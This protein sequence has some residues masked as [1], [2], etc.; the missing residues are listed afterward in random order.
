MKDRNRID[1]FV[2]RRII[3]ALLIVIP[4]VIA[5]VGC[6]QK[7]PADAP[8]KPPSDSPPQNRPDLLQNQNSKTSIA[9][10][11]VFFLDENTGWVVGRNGVILH[12]TNGGVDWLP[13]PS[14]TNENLIDIKFI[15]KTTGWAA[16]VNRVL[17]TTNGGA[18]WKDVWDTTT[19]DLTEEETDDSAANQSQAAL[20]SISFSDARHGWALA[21]GL[22]PATSKFSTPLVLTTLDGG[23]SWD[24]LVIDDEYG[25]ITAVDNKTCVV[26]GKLGRLAQTTDGGKTW[27]RRSSLTEDDITAI[28]FSS[29]KLGWATGTRGTII[30]SV[31]G[32][33][34]WSTVYKQ[35]GSDHVVEFHNIRF[36]DESHGAAVGYV[37]QSKND[38]NSY[39][40]VTLVST[41]GGRDWQQH[42]VGTVDFIVNSMS[43]IKPES[44]WAVGGAG[45]ILRFRSE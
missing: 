7:P 13:Q 42:E 41:N 27:E 3:F 22:D 32:G 20:I 11:K 33:K 1:I 15:N 16:S 6:E 21:L 43:I 36:S 4:L 18:T 29:P 31:D 44:C 17:S 40:L 39:L 35:T 9:L 14:G 34:T 38:K 26:G 10:N 8:P 45:Q 2:T 19:I 23:E 24:W 5:S 12:T 30:G 37:D 25:T 28:T